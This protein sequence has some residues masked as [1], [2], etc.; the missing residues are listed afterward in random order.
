[1]ATDLMKA[2][3]DARRILKGFK[4]FAEVADALEAAGQVEQRTVEAQR[5]LAEI[6]PQVAA[7]R[8]EIDKA[9]AEAKQVLADAK[10]Q[11]DKLVAKA[12]DRASEILAAAQAEASQA[13]TDAD[14]LV[15]ERKGAAVSAAAARDTALVKRDALLKECNELEARLAKAQASIAKLLG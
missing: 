6:Q 1:M 3:D 7:A 15:A 2:A 14:Q 8:A 4:A 11:A 5:V 10:A 13:L 9:Q 12:E